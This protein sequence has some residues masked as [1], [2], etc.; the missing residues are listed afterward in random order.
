M[1]RLINL[2]NTI[3]E[4]ESFENKKLKLKLKDENLPNII[5]S[6][7]ETHKKRLKE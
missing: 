3:M 1:K 4:Y 7:V 6:L 5:K 2:V